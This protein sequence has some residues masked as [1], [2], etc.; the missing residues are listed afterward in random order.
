MPSFMNLLADN[1]S[2]S[3]QWLLY[4]SWALVALFAGV[5][6]AFSYHQ[7][8]WVDESTQLSGLTLSF[9]DLYRWLGGLIDNPFP[10][11]SDRMPMLSY[12]VGM[13]WGGIWGYDVLTMRW[14]SIVLVVSG[15]VGMIVFFA[16]RHQYIVLFIAL[17]FLCLSPNLTI[18]AVEIRAYALFFL[19]SLIAVLIYI[20]IVL[21]VENERPI[22]KKIIGLSLVLALAVNTHFFGLVLAGSLLSTYLL[23]A[24]FDRRFVFKAKYFWQV[25]VILGLAIT[26]IVLP[27][28]AS[29][30]S[31]AGGKASHSIL[32]PAVK[33]LY[34]LVGHQ[35]MQL[36][37]FFPIAAL[38][39][40]YLTILLSLYKKPSLIKWSLA[41]M[42]VIG[43]TAVFL[44]NVFLSNFDALAAHYNIWMLPI[45]A[46]LFAYS[47]ADFLPAKRYV[48]VGLMAF[49]LGMGQYTL[50]F[51][52][53]KYAHTRF[54]QIQARI[55]EYQAG[56]ALA[57]IYNKPMAK[58]WFAARY[59]FSEY[60]GQYSVQ[61]R[62]AQYIVSS[63]GYINLQTD[64][65][66]TQAS[67]AARY[68]VII[69]AY[70]ENIFTDELLA[71][72][73]ESE[74][75]DNSPAYQ[76]IVLSQPLWRVVDAKRY[77]SQESAELVVYKKTP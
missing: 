28:L 23:T 24:V 27:V 12:W 35:S 40:C 72:K 8:L 38:A 25:G 49:F 22:D 65:R 18:T 64:E 36:V 69:S 31:Q 6:L 73:A 59:T 2:V 52:G 55:D 9:V 3:R 57:I 61:E 42:L 70:G 1:K 30:T 37:P 67:I 53:E 44:A 66:V 50:A 34:R 54:D 26:F 4:G 7:N 63:E 17:L 32:V 41:L 46:L 13:I 5:A 43:F 58:T 33:L 48:I 29:F 21:S 51:S 62:P 16:R 47:V 14:L 74:L 75:P 60:S 45:V 71:G 77:L 68:D 11:P 76:H 39:V 19:L 10:V 20:D 56:N 15:L